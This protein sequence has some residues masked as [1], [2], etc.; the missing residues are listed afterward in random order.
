MRES[1]AG[2][3]IIGT[4]NQGRNNNDMAGLKE[5]K[6]LVEGRRKRMDQWG[7]DL[8]KQEGGMREGG[9][10]KRTVRDKG[11]TREEMEGFLG[12]TPSLQ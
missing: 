12:Y 7:V 11:Y 4:N 8:E 1:R 9:R 2:G 10:M 5:I 3:S 6:R